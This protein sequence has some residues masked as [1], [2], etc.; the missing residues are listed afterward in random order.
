[1]AIFTHCPQ[2]LTTASEMKKDKMTKKLVPVNKASYEAYV[3]CVHNKQKN[4][5]QNMTGK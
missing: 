4:S 3:L 1:M 5:F 2:E